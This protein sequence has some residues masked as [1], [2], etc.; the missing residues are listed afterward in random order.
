MK[1]KR[2]AMELSMNTIVVVV[3]GVTLLVLGLVFVRGLFD[4]LQNQM[5]VLFGNADNDLNQISTHDQEISLQQ[6]VNV[7]QGEGATFKVW[8]TNLENSAGMFTIEAT[9][10]STNN[11]GNKVIVDFANPEANLDVGQEIG[12][13][14][15]IISDKNAPLT[16]GGYTINVY[17]DGVE[18]ASGGFFVMVEK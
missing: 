14:T 11:F 5:D 2:G 15:G 16:S 13:V 4:N 3:I 17:K 10:S 12:F 6:Q 7:K 1:D 8:V 18:Y 9:P